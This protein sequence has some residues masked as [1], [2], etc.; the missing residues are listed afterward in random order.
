MK[1]D[2]LVSLLLEIFEL[3][4]VFV[5]LILNYVRGLFDGQYTR[6]DMEDLPAGTYTFMLNMTIKSLR[7]GCEYRFPYN[8][9]YMFFRDPD[10]L[11]YAYEGKVRVICT[12]YP[13]KSRFN[14]KFTMNGTD[15]ELYNGL[16]YGDSVNILMFN[17]KSLIVTLLPCG[18][19]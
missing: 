1:I 17:D 9:H 3:L 16:F 2:S 6:E 18:E 10:L 12:E 8:I 7:I 19:N 14:F 5:D 11:D 13:R 4:I 15:Y